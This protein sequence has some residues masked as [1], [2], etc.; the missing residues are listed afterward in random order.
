MTFYGRFGN[1]CGMP[2][3]KDEYFNKNIQFDNFRP[4]LK[5]RPSQPWTELTINNNFSKKQ[6][7][8]Y[9]KKKYIKKNTTQKNLENSQEIL[10]SN[11]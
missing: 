6:D 5:Y 11:N 10:K 7:K 9:K 1:S 2:F 3:L 4:Y 8:T